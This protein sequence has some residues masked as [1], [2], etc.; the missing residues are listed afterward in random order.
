MQLPKDLL[1]QVAALNTIKTILDEQNLFSHN[2]YLQK[3]KRQNGLGVLV[4]EITSMLISPVVSLE[5]RNKFKKYFLNIM[6]SSDDM[7]FVDVET[8]RKT[9]LFSNE[10]LTEIQKQRNNG[11]ISLAPIAAM[12]DWKM[13]DLKSEKIF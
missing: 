5:S 13:G 7:K 4:D 2:D 1:I 3:Y 12:T 6:L 9:N 8:I 11:E 10:E